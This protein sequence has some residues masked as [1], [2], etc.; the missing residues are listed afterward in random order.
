MFLS[1]IADEAAR[2]AA[3][4][5]SAHR[6][7]GWSHIELRNIDGVNAAE[8]PDRGM[9]RD[10]RLQQRQVDVISAIERKTGDLVFVHQSA[11]RTCRRVHQ[12]RFSGNYDLLC[13]SSN[14]Q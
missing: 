14:L 11:E 9:G 3:R 7:L 4:Q 2:D 12:R 6:E 13:R 8:M 1:G 5:A 10:S